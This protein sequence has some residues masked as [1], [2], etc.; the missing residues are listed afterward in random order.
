[1]L[2]CGPMGSALDADT[3]RRSTGLYAE[4]LREHREEINS[5]NVFPMPDGDTE[6]WA[7]PT[8]GF[9]VRY[10]LEAESEGARVADLRRELGGSGDSVVVVGGGGLY[11]VHVHTDEP[12]AAVEAGLAAGIPSGVSWAPLRSAAAQCIG[13][14]A[15]KVQAASQL[16]APV[17]VVQG[18]GLQAAFR[19]LG[20]TGVPAEPSRLPSS[21]D[22]LP[23][24]DASPADLVLALPNHPD[25]LEAADRTA[26]GQPV[27]VGDWI[28]T[29]EGVVLVAA[30][31]PADAA[32]RLVGA[33]GPPDSELVTVDLGE[34]PD[35]DASEVMS[36]VRRALARAEVQGIR[37]GHPGPR[38]VIGVE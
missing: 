2:P 33:L 9:E 11:N 15:R 35:D 12:Q 18:R 16:S 38:Y 21:N 7:S 5:L 29:E 24:I 3:L 1:M 37:G 36:A 6:T 4:A 25:V 34:G 14:Q 20:A 28:E 23:A 27:G 19:S 13:G 26:E 17:A 10:L 8:L 22:L 31:T 30:A 32:G